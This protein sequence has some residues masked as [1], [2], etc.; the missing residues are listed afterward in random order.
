MLRMK[1]YSPSSRI[2]VRDSIDE[3]LSDDID[4]DVFIRDGKLVNKKQNSI[5]LK[6]NESTST[7]FPRQNEILSVFRC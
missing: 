2:A 1:P 7:S 4:D 5:E 6:L 3:E